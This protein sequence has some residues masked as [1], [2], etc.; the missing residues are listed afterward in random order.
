M[1]LRPFAL[2]RYF[3]PYEQVVPYLFSSSDCEPLSLERLLTFADHEAQGLWNDLR[4]GYTDSQGLPVLRQE[5]ANLYVNVSADDVV[6][7]VPEEGILL[8]MHALLQPGDHVITMFPAYQSLYEVARDVGCAI[9]FWTPH[10]RD[11]WYFDP[12]ALDRLLRPTTR[13]LVINFPHNP[14]GYLPSAHEFQV[15]VAW[16]RQR[17]IR[18]FS[19]EMYRFLEF[20]PED[21]L[22][23]AVDCDDQA[24]VLFGM[25]KSFGLAGLRIGWL[26]TRDRAALDRVKELK[27]YTTICA[28]APAEVLALIGLRARLTIVAEHLT[29]IQRN[30]SLLDIFVADHPG[31]VSPVRPRAGSVCLA[32]LNTGEPASSFC[33]RIVEEAGVMVLP[34]TVFD[35]GDRHIRIGLGRESFPD[36]LQNFARYVMERR[37]VEA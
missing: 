1:T 12:S 13:L 15:V 29:R 4:L 24:L 9:D 22:P 27:D 5:I 26:V 3:A 25:S 18:I 8:A 11:G 2:E 34:S 23:S 7:V 35:F 6:V 16:A 20:V 37:N 21:R 19:D 17:G 31:L 28:S 36:V 10:E 33:R 30:L 14:T 32:R